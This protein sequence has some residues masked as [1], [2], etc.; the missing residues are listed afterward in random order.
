MPMAKAP[1][2]LYFFLFLS[3][4]LFYSARRQAR[5]SIQSPFCIGDYYD[6]CHYLTPDLSGSVLDS[7]T[8]IS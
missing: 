7:P 8:G 5:Q 3:Y 2:K 6:I 4:L 1:Q